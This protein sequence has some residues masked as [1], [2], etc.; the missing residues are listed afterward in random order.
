MLQKCLEGKPW[1]TIAK[2][3]K[4]MISF[5]KSGFYKKI[6]IVNKNSKHYFK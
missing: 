6:S 4:P 1:Q 2:K 3:P 5:T